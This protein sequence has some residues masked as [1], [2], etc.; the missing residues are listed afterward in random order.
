MAT[1]L[2]TAV[3]IAREAGILLGQFYEQRIG[4]ELKGDFDLVTA[5]DRASEQLV[6]SRLKQ[7]YPDHSIVAEEGGGHESGGDY[8]WYVDPLDGTT[9]FAHGFPVFNVTLAL[10]RRGEM[11]A[12]VVL[13]PIRHEEFTAELGGG[14]YLNHKRIRVSTA[15]AVEHTLVATGFPS[16]GRQ[17]NINIHFYHQLAMSA[18]GV[19]RCGAAALDLANVA[20]GRLDAFWEFGL[21]PWD[22]AAGRLLITEA[23]GQ[24]TDMHGAPHTLES[25]H[26]LVSN[27]LVHAEL[28]TVFD[29][30]FRGKQRYPMPAIAPAP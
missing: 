15:A 20:C 4:F 16:R 18:H 14:A 6:V 26:L 17:Q 30:V 28:L 5:A 19:R 13:D 21:N 22:L 3:E 2:E 24:A 9:N 11:I 7:H 1:F 27:G 23:G 29:E 12:G 10:E 25:P 8:R